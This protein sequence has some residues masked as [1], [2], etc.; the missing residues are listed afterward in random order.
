MKFKKKKK[1][2]NYYNHY[3]VFIRKK[4]INKKPEY[5][6][7]NCYNKNLKVTYIIIQNYKILKKYI[8]F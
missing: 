8:N 6:K 7:I 1:K 2:I 4:S 3:C 5:C